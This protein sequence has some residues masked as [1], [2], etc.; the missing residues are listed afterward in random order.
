MKPSYECELLE[1]VRTPYG[2]YVAKIR[3]L[4]EGHPSGWKIGARGYTTNIISIDFRERLFFTKN[5]I[6]QFK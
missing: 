6:Y 4:S 3:V 1:I 5:S 2:G